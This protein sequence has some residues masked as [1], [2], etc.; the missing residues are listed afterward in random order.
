M[1]KKGKA[2]ASFYPQ[3][4]SNYQIN[5]QWYSGVF[6]ALVFPVDRITFADIDVI[7]IS[8]ATVAVVIILIFISISPKLS[9]HKTQTH[10]VNSNM[11]LESHPH[12]AA[13]MLEVFEV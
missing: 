5:T 2:R 3:S 12:I 1:Q 6:R 9:K 13:F 4:I 10:N 11:C 7:S 8:T